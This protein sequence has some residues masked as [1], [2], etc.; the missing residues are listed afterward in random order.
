MSRK[1]ARF[2]SEL[3]ERTPLVAVCL[4]FVTLWSG[5][6]V[7]SSGMWA[8]SPVASYDC[9]P[10][11][12]L[13]PY[14]SG[15]LGIL[16]NTFAR[17]YLAVAYRYLSAHPP[18]SAAA[19]IFVQL[20][21]TRIGRDQPTATP[22]PKT[23]DPDGDED[24][25]SQWLSARKSV[26]GVKPLKDIDTWSTFKNGTYTDSFVNCQDAAF[27]N[28]TR[29]LSERVKKFG[30]S[31]KEVKSW[32]AAQDQVFCNCSVQPVRRD[33]NPRPAGPFLPAP[34]SAGDPEIIKKDRQ[35]QIACA[36]FYASKF[37]EAEKAF[38]AIAA[39]VKSPW[40]KLAPYLAARAL[41]RR[42]SL[43]T[44][45]KVPA[46]LSR[47]QLLLAR[48]S[49][50]PSAGELK[51]EANKLLRIVRCRQLRLPEISR[52]FQTEKGENL[53]KAF[54][55]LTMTIDAALPNSI[56]EFK[57][58]PRSVLED[59]LVDW[60][61]TYQF[62]DNGAY[63]HAVEQWKR[64]GALHWLLACISKVEVGDRE[65]PALLAGASKVQP[66]SPAYTTASYHLIRLWMETGKTEQARSRL[67]FMLAQPLPLTV[68]NAFLE[69]R[70][71]VS[72]NIDEFAADCVVVPA[73]AIG[74]EDTPSW[75]REGKPAARLPSMF[76][77][78]IIDVINSKLPLNRMLHIAMNSP[79]PRHLRAD[80]LKA[81][82]VRAVMLGNDTIA[83]TA[84]GPLMKVRPELRQ[85]LTA[86]NT[87]KSPDERRYASTFA[88]MRCPGMRPYF[89][90]GSMRERSV[91][92][93][94]LYSDNWWVEPTGGTT[95]SESIS[96][97]LSR[98]H[99]PALDYPA[100]L[101][102]DERRQTVKEIKFLEDLGCSANYL[103]KITI[104]W[105]RRAKQDSRLPEALH[106]AVMTTRYGGTDD[107]TSGLS[108]QAF[109]I[110]QRNYAGTRWA[111]E[112]QY[113]F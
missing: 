28:A 20:W 72:R 59:D 16:K 53:Y 13:E 15:K 109:Q 52:L 17:S 65:L 54:D 1:S 68:R 56:E 73:S 91:D 2:N 14:A 50:D 51:D 94:D 42:S 21:N 97:K 47:A 6:P 25:L 48:I 103:T 66:A 67:D 81:V 102:A 9:F 33:W 79:L 78:S 88:I 57:Q 29:V 4:L 35:Y 99:L 49:A 107:E 100:F 77:A 111:K 43:Q 62:L 80:A 61:L 69:E 58:V 71:C 113:C 76:P 101:T 44:N 86:Y 110:L 85:L 60:V 90:C 70:V 37:D 26:P 7:V 12:P 3:K 34:P 92:K 96:E 36:Y 75:Y 89:T 40:R 22:D 11:L 27:A 18:D 10:D 32:L 74:D 24:A 105:A 106:L 38:M 108:R 63:A 46:L 23:A 112:T 95:D 93:M 31:G 82:W 104:D 19:A 64:T 98:G 45:D 84:S 87:A 83:R 55:D 8:P 30:S 41:L 5:A 39:D